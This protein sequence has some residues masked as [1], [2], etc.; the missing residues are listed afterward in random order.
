[1][2]S[3]LKLSAVPFVFVFAAAA[4]AQLGAKISGQAN[5]SVFD[6]V[7]AET[8]D[9][10]VSQGNADVEAH[11]DMHTG[12]MRG[13]ARVFSSTHDYAYFN[14]RL[15]DFLTI[16]GPGTDAVAFTINLD[17]S[18]TRSWD[19]L[20]ANTQ[21][22]DMNAGARMEV[23]ANNV[24]VVNQYHSN[25]DRLGTIDGEGHG[26]IDETYDTG[27]QVGSGQVIAESHDQ[28]HILM[29]ATMMVK[30]G[31]EVDFVKTMY[32][33]AQADKGPGCVVDAMHSGHVS[34]SLPDG[35]SFTSRAG[36]FLDTAVPEPSSMAVLGLGL[37]AVLRRRRK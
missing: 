27:F 33:S 2:F 13:L 14:D 11:A 28:F 9:Y 1:M 15:S 31:D 18:M 17:V 32:G 26:K 20:L 34:I 22:E 16:V 10:S 24:S 12:T 21:E 8:V 36:G 19:N 30:P 25:F 6:F 35:Y 23:L 37:V 5:S 29:S 7:P 3:K 4:E